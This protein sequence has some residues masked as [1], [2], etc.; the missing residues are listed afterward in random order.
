MDERTIGLII[1]MKQYNYDK[2]VRDESITLKDIAIEYMMEYS[3]CNKKVYTKNKIESIIFESFCD[4]IDAVDKPSYYIKELKK[5]YDFEE[6]SNGNGDIY[7]SMLTVM[8]MVA[9]YD[10]NKYINGFKEKDFNN[11]TCETNIEFVDDLMESLSME[12]REQM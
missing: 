1:F 4:F 7:E 8:E 6:Y 9:V 2:Y 5:D 3:G 12:Q 10:G 11:K